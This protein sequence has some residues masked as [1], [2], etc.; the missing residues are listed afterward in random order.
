MKENAARMF[1]LIESPFSRWRLPELR[2]VQ[3]DDG[4]TQF[5]ITKDKSQTYAVRFEH[6]LAFKCTLEGHSPWSSEANTVI[7]DEGCFH[8]V[9]NSKWIRDFDQLQ[10]LVVYTFGKTPLTHYAILGTDFE[11]E[12]LSPSSPEWGTAED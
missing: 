6:I 8:K 12:I 5:V 1:S 2:I 3:S 11:I 10:G 7:D 9:E 4:E